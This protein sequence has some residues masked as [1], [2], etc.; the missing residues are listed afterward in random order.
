LP[1]PACRP[2][3]TARGW[4]ACGR[5]DLAVLRELVHAGQI[6]PVIGRA[7][8]LSEVAEAIGYLETGHARRKVGITV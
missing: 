7:R 8:S 4:S 2:E 5:H 6:A 1:M 3:A